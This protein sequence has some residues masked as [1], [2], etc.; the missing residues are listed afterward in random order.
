MNKRKAWL[1][2]LF[3]CCLFAFA[4]CGDAAPPET[5]K[6]VIEGVPISNDEQTQVT[7]SAEKSM[8]G[9]EEAVDSGIQEA[10]EKR[11]ISE[12]T[13]IEELFRVTDAY[14]NDTAEYQEAVKAYDQTMGPQTLEW[15]K[16]NYHAGCGNA[17]FM[18]GYVD[19][20]DIPE[21]F[22][23]YGTAHVDGVHV[24]TYS[25]DIKEVIRVG[26]FSSFGGIYYSFRKNRIL[27]QYGN[28]GFYVEY[29]SMIKEGQPELVDVAI[30]DGGGIRHDGVVGF[31]GFE[32]P[33]GVD[34]SREGFA[35][36]GISDLD[37]P[38]DYPS[39]EY[40]ISDE[41]ESQLIFDFLGNPEKG[42]LINVNYN[43]MYG[44]QPTNEGISIDIA[45]KK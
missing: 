15:I 45:G 41:E 13:S 2:G 10:D 23:A 44:V 16:E 27:S 18:V 34:G 43:G 11:F 7:S 36:L 38:E 37:V 12:I 25:P 8:S 29:V 24:F 22:L 42:E 26:E 14:W 3:T 30:N 17:K 9:G 35:Q 19:E 21:L 39:D 31:Y 40:L 1:L 5:H 33:D 32:I 28:H 6:E 20:D 4:S